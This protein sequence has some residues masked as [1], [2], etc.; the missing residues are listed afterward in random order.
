MSRSLKS[1]PSHLLVPRG[2]EIYSHIF[3]NA[4]TGLARKLIWSITVDFQPIMYGDDEFTCSMTCEWIPWP[5]RDWRELDGRQLNVEYGQNGVESSF[6][7][8]RHD[9]AT[10]TALSIR[11]RRD[12]VFSVKVDMLVDFQ[13]YYGGDANPAMPIRAEV[14]VSFIGLLVIPGNLF[15]KP[16][17]HA[18]LQKVASE[19]VDL[20]AYQ[21][22]ETWK[23]HG[24]V[25]RP[26]GF[27]EP[28]LQDLALE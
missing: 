21:G 1:F 4:R 23:S 8:G 10:H 7:M 20:S 18:E 19:F 28:N 26:V 14:D 16:N 12:N 9:L 5:I 24:F 15:P 6:Y 17:S 3:E 2:G 13:G 11:R 27:A 25:F 22:P